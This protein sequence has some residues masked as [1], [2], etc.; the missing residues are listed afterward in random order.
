[1]GTTHLRKKNLLSDDVVAD[2]AKFVVA[3]E[4]LNE[5]M[6]HNGIEVIGREHFSHSSVRIDGKHDFGR[7]RSKF[8]AVLL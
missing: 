3:D 2:T 6:R 4:L 7:R 8:F 1:M 5:I